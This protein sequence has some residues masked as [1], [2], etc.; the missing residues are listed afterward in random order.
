MQ[1][2]VGDD[3]KYHHMFA[4]PRADYLDIGEIGHMG[5]KKLSRV[6]TGS[7]TRKSN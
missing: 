1:D 3:G 4:I 6:S 5:R 7:G 2:Q